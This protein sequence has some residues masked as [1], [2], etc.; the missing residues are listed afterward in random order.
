MEKANP[1]NSY[2]YYPS[3]EPWTW[4]Q[5]YQEAVESPEEQSNSTTDRNN[6]PHDRE[7][8]DRWAENTEQNH[9]GTEQNRQSK[10]LANPEIGHRD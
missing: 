4:E 3:E 5:R 6:H 1:E 7:S 2:K 10:D 9:R 8:Y